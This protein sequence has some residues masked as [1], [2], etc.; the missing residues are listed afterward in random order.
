MSRMPLT[1]SQK[2]ALIICGIRTRP[3][4][5]TIALGTREVSVVDVVLRNAP[6]LRQ[7]PASPPGEGEVDAADQADRPHPLLQAHRRPDHRAPNDVAQCMNAS[8][9]TATTSSAAMNSTPKIA[10]SRQ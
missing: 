4:P 2:P 1:L 5:N 7:R 8:Q 10:P 6:V 9:G 3:V